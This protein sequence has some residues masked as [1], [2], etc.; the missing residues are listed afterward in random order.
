MGTGHQLLWV[1]KNISMPIIL[2]ENLHHAFQ[3]NP[4][5][6]KK[7]DQR[8]KRDGELRKFDKERKQY[9]LSSLYNTTI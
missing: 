2:F 4:A 8:F 6:L 5:F 9:V 3:E 1:N 7:V